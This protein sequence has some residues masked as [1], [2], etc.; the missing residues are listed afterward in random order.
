MVRNLGIGIVCKILVPEILVVSSRGIWN[1]GTRFGYIEFYR[2][3]CIRS[4][5]RYWV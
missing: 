5:Y 4:K 3:Y 2:Q 1:I